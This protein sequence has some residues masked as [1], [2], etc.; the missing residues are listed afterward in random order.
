[1]AEG[2]KERFDLGFMRWIWNY[3]KRT[4]PKIVRML[5][6]NPDNKRIIWLRTDAEVERFLAGIKNA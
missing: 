2:C 6:E 3:K 5:K 1:M 4:R